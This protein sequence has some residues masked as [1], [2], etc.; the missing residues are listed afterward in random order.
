MNNF[1]VAKSQNFY[2]RFRGWLVSKC[3]VGA[4]LVNAA[5]VPLGF[6]TLAR[7]SGCDWFVSSVVFAI[8]ILMA[9]VTDGMSLGSCARLRQSRVAIDDVKSRYARAERMTDALR[10]HKDADL[11]PHHTSIKL[12][13]GMLIFFG[14]VSALAGDVFLHILFVH[15]GWLGWLTSTILALMVTGTMVACEL[16][17][18]ENLQLIEEC[19]QPNKLLAAALKADADES[20]LRELA[21]QYSAEI[22]RLATSTDTIRISVSEHA[23]DTYD[24]LL[25]GG[26]GRLPQRIVAE[27]KQEEETERHEEEFTRGQLRLIRGGG[28]ESESARS[29]TV[30]QRIY[31]FL[32]DSP[33]AT[34]AEI[35]S[36]LDINP[37]TV[38]LYAARIRKA[39]A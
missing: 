9:V 7:Q 19:V 13:V 36:E 16:F 1:S 2:R 25:G 4:I 5:L 33:H 14:L 26:L 11:L 17:Y 15:M 27:A 20:A 35:A 28:N 22:G 38:R 21:K 30:Y 37:N 29:T 18:K 10:Q 31:D 12:S 3:C 24:K 6:L 32:Q 34:N 23:M 8:G 39:L